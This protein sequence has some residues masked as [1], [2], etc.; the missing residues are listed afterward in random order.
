MS[1]PSTSSPLQRLIQYYRAPDYFRRLRDLALPLFAQQFLVAALNML[2]VVLLGRI[3][4]TAVAA[5][6]LAGQ[7]FFLLNL[8][9][10]G[11]ISGSAIFTAQ[12]WGR[13]DLPGLRRA[14]GL[15]LVLA[16]AASLLF[17]TLSE[18]FPE[19]ILQV[20]SKDPAVISMGSQYLRLYAWTYFSYA[21][22]LSFSIV[23]RSVG[24]VRMPTTIS[25]GTGLLNIL[26]AYGLMFGSLGLPY[27]GV[28]GAA[29]AA[30]LT[31][32][33][34]CVLILSATYLKNSPVAARPS[35]LMQVDFQ[36]ARRFFQPVLPVILNE[37]LWSF[38][39]T[40]YSV[41]YGNMNTDA[42]AA[43]NI[44]STLDQLALVLFF[45]ISNATAVMV[46]NQIGAGREDEA[47]R[48]A[49]RS[50]GLGALGGVLV[51]ILIA[52]IKI[53]LLTLYDVPPNVIADVSRVLVVISCFLWLRIQN[54]M[55]VV[56]ILRAGG[57]T[58]F[59]L[60]LDGIIIWVVG[61]PLAALGAFAF[62]LP[63]HL[64][65]L[66]AMSEETTK[67]CL[68]LPRYFSRKWIRN[69]AHAV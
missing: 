16:L 2:A 5:V 30:V 24:D 19:A 27:L 47:F 31:R 10:F 69:L 58:L 23:L 8:L 9:L 41:I 17:F 40:A 57:D 63:V 29:W 20:Y 38:G 13:Q 45:S 21:I 37:T 66:C 68:G 39:T 52:L 4:E 61:V 62:Q 59:S 54:A 28:L 32:G 35:E 60:F 48:T 33:L 1:L 22:S 36:F 34:E 49:G 42:I 12:F 64:V 55:I 53:P 7:V 56:G 14:L 51:G 18:L 11:I 67:W 25:M 15:G 46:G 6:G 50:L 44:V 26:L 65:Y 43:M 3:S